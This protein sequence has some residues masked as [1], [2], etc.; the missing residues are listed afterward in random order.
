[1]PPQGVLIKSRLVRGPNGPF[2]K[3]E[4]EGVLAADGFPQM[5]EGQAK[6]PMVC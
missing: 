5:A 1:M 6:F 3:V 2:V 4:F